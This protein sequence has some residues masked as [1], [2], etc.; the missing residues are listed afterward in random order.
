MNI[1]YE[2]QEG[3]PEVSKLREILDLYESIFKAKFST[4]GFIYEI[5]NSKNLVFNLAFSKHK[6]IGFKV[7]FE[8]KDRSFY[9]WLGGI[10]PDFRGQGIAKKLMDLQHSWLKDNKFT[11]VTTPSSNQYKSMLI[12]NLK[13]GFDLTGT[14]INSKGEQRLILR[15]G[16]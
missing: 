13:N 15:K 12:L 1:Q 9:S 11:S 6:L 4:N 7:G 8:K 5:E 2:L 3:L 16:L 10:A 14:N